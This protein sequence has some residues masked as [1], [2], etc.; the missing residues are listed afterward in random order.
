M[1]THDLRPAHW[2]TGSTQKGHKSRLV[3]DGHNH[4][5]YGPELRNCRVIMQPYEIGQ[6][7]K[8]E[9]R[10]KNE[11][12]VDDGQVIL[13]GENHYGDDTHETERQQAQRPGYSF[14]ILRFVISFHRSVLPALH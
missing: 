7:A 13:R 11:K 5:F 14:C 8:G 9:W 2:R 3:T 6:S 10:A 1:M 12:I 4:H